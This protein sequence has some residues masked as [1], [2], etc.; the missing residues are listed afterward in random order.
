MIQ[1]IIPS[2]YNSELEEEFIKLFH[3][4]DLSLHFNKTRDKKFTNYQKILF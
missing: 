1:Q 3:F 4:L 2:N